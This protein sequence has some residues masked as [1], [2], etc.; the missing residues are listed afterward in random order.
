MLKKLA[1]QP[2]LQALELYH[3]TLRLSLDLLLLQSDLLDST[4]LREANTLFISEV[5]K[6][7]DL[8]A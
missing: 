4:E 2:A 7:V 1:T 8:P 5:Q 3:T 6:T